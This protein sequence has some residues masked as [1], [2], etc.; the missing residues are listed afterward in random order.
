MHNTL[1]AQSLLLQ[2][3][4]QLAWAPDQLPDLDPR[5]L[6]LRTRAGAISLGTELPLYL[7][8]ARRAQPPSYPIMTGYETI[9]DVVACGAAVQ[10][11]TVGDRV[12]AFYGHRT[13]A[14]V[15][16]SRVVPIPPAI[17]DNL[18]V[19]LILACDTAKGISK[20][21]LHLQSRIAITGSGPIGL[22]TLF[23][24]HAHGLRDIVVIDPVAHRRGVAQAFGA[25]A[26]GDTENPGIDTN[27]CQAGFECSSRAAAFGLLQ[28]LVQP[29]GHLCILADGNLEPLTLTPAFH[30]KELTVVGSSDGLDYRAYAAWFWDLVRTERYPLASVFEQTVEAPALPEVFAHLAAADPC[31]L[32]VFVQYAHG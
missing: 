17:P 3:P 8:Q 19:L 29:G 11:V 13:A 4:R 12:V 23:N 15:P 21:P 22:L 10:T 31:P 26:T 27:S 30:T 16:E 14:V 2:R 28:D 18:A 9:A 20:V 24:L 1:T 6:L 32:K 7:G 25:R 5:D